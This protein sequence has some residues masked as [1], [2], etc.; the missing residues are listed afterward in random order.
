[1]IT[2]GQRAVFAKGHINIEGDMETRLTTVQWS[3]YADVNITFAIKLMMDAQGISF[4]EAAD[5]IFSS[6]TKNT[7]I[8]SFEVLNV[9]DDYS[10]RSMNSPR[11]EKLLQTFSDDDE[12]AV[13]ISGK[14]Q[15][16]YNDRNDFYEVH[17]AKN[18]DKVV[19]NHHHSQDGV[20]AWYNTF[21]QTVKFWVNPKYNIGRSLAVNELTADNI[22]EVMEKLEQD[23]GK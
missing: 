23:F 6:I 9:K 3:M 17:L 8:S 15:E 12:V 14:L 10:I 11:S 7:H 13:V 16:K 20:C 19:E 1:M 2:M 22:D 18:I 4:A 5:S 21:T